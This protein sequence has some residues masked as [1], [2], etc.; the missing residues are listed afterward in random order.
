MAQSEAE[1]AAN[2]LADQ[3][4]RDADAQEKVDRANVRAQQAQKNRDA[5][6]L[7]Q[8]QDAKERAERRAR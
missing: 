5:D 8:A 6:R 4:R 1:K 7:R 3:R 2:R